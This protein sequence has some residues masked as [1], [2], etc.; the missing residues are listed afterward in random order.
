[1]LRKNWSHFTICSVVVLT[2]VSPN[3]ATAAL[4]VGSTSVTSDGALN[5]NGAAT[6]ALALGSNATIGSLSVGTSLTSGTYTLG[7]TL[8][9]GSITIGRSNASQSII[10]GGSEALGPD[11][12]QTIS[13]GSTDQ[14]D[15]SATRIINIG[16]GELNDAFYQAI[17]IGTTDAQN[18]FTT[19]D[20]KIFGTN[21]WLFSNNV[22]H[23][24]AGVQVSNYPSI[25]TT[26]IGKITSA[27]V[28]S[29][30]VVGQ[31]AGTPVG[32]NV[33][34]TKGRITTDTTA[35]TSVTVTFSSPYDTAPAC[36]VTPGNAAAAQIVGGANSVYITTTTNGFT[37]THDSSSASAI[38]YYTC[39]A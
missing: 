4:T 20:T 12:A 17:T 7:G 39:I 6:S 35:H 30:P 32:F 25:G 18:G 13:I 33:T 22:D 11:V 10:I 36:T 27:N 24:G 37:I 8:Q 34:D 29:A 28:G 23:Y 1:M 16:G 9:T 26:I 2:L 3:L 14:I 5:L 15:S 38:W 19:A 21:V 31:N